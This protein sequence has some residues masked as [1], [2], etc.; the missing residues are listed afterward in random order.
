MEIKQSVG[1]YNAVYIIEV[2]DILKCFPNT[3]SNKTNTHFTL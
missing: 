3:N 1:I 2:I